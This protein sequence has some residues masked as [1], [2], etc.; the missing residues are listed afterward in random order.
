MIRYLLLLACQLA[1]STQ[2]EII[3]QPGDTLNKVLRDNHVAN[4]SIYQINAHAQKLAPI[5]SLSPNDTII[6][7]TSNQSKQLLSAR[8]HTKR[9]TYVLNLTNKQYTIQPITTDSTVDIVETTSDHNTHSPKQVMAQR[10]ASVLFPNQQGMIAAAFKDNEIISLKITSQTGSN[11]AF[12]D[13]NSTFPTYYQASGKAITPAIA[14][15]PTNYKRVSSPFNPNRLHPISKK[16]LPHKGVDLAAPM[17][18]P[19]WAAASGTIIHKSSDTGYGNMLIIDHGKGI[20]TY[21]AH[22]NKFHSNIA[23]GSKVSG[24]ETIGYVGSTGHSTGPHLHFETR[25]DNT[26]YD[27]LTFSKQHLK[28]KDLASPQFDFYF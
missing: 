25:I 11:Y 26:P 9:K 2:Q 28:T 22:L 17:N 12:L 1:W 3:I 14:R 6:I 23:I 21:Y 8:L 20:H 10:A 13:K 4:S 7:T 27:P 15:T 16:V 19:I 24:F 18:T 5:S